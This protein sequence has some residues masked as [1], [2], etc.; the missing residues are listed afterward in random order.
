MKTYFVYILLCSN[1]GYYTGL[2]TQLHQRLQLHQ[3]G[4][5][6]DFTRKHLPVK[7]VYFETTHDYKAA[8]LREKQIRS[9][10]RAKKKALSMGEFELLKKLAECKNHTH[11]KNKH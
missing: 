1:N 9:W 2:T 7:L 11:Y 3:N 4:L 10:S 8:I 5:I 6:S